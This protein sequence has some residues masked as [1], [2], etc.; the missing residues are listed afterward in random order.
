MK[1]QAIDRPIIPRGLA[2]NIAI[3]PSGSAVDLLIKP[4]KMD[5]SI[6][7]KAL[8]SIE[9][10]FI[11]AIRVIMQDTMIAIIKKT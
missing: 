4:P 8:L 1:I 6:P 11:K 3:K 7:I 9:Y 5:L 10:P 2:A